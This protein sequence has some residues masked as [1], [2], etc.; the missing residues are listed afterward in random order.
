MSNYYEILGVSEEASQE[1]IK[2][3]YR[4]LAVK[5][6][7]DKGEE[8]SDE[9]IKEINEAYDVLSNTEK[10]K[11]YDMERQGSPFGQSIFDD[12][13]KNMHARR[14]DP[15]APMRGRD[16]KH[17]LKLPIRFFIFGGDYSFEIQYPDT[18]NSCGGTGAAERK[19]CPQCN[20]SGQQ[21]HKQQD[22]NNVFIR[23]VPCGSCSGRG[24]IPV[25]K[26]PDCDGGQIHID[27]EVT[28][29]LDKDTPPG[30]VISKQGEGLS[31]KNGGPPGDLY[32]KVYFELPREKDLTPEQK[33]A[34]STL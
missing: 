9:K 16:I 34:L 29:S 31:G 33:E 20:G 21:T 23:T 14:R 12:I 24:F 11:Q 22:G 10:R 28:I 27:K 19:T 6:H 4:K 30:Q 5:H 17:L 7:P 25:K 26:C 13:F 2:K 18:C 32:V 15:N 3:A 8:A 1:E